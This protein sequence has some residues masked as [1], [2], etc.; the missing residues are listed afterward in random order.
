MFEKAGFSRLSM[1]SRALRTETACIA[2]AA[3][4]MEKTEGI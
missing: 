2:A 3:F 1:G 4:A